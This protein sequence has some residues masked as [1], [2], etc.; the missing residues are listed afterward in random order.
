MAKKC[1]I[2]EENEAE[3]KI[4]DSSEV[5]C[6][7]CAIEHFGD[8]SMLVK[9]E[10]EAQRLKRLIEEKTSQDEEETKDEE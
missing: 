3:Y 2:C 8:I 6:K 10:E 9:V 4:K 5:Y 1:I 7:E